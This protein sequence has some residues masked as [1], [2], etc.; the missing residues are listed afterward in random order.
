[1]KIIVRGILQ[2]LLK[3]WTIRRW[4]DGRWDDGRWDDCPSNPATQRIVLEI[5]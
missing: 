5:D 3:Y 1:M 2:K 4:D